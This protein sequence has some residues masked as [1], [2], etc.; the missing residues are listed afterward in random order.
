MCVSLLSLAVRCV[1][2]LLVRSRRVSDMKDAELRVLRHE[3]AALLGRI[4][5]GSPRHQRI[6]LAKLGVV[7]AATRPES[8]V[9]TQPS[10]YRGFGE[11]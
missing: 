8:P 4:P 7:V 5:V 6:E 1:L 3:F 10:P 2:G 9:E 11:T